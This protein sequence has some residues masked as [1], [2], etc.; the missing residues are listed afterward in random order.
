MKL[1]ML[2]LTFHSLIGIV[3]RKVKGVYRN[4]NNYGA[5]IFA[6]GKAISVGTFKTRKEAE[7]A[8]LSKR[9]ELGLRGFHD[10]EG[11]KIYICWGNMIQRCTNPNNMNYH[12]Y[13]KRGITVCRRW[14]DFVKFYEDMGGIPDGKSL[15]RIDN[16]GN[17][18]PLN[19]KWSTRSEQSINQR[20]RSDNKSGVKGVTWNSQRSKWVASIQIRGLVKKLY[21]GNDFF[22]AVCLRKS[23]ELTLT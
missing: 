13:G 9:A 22:E 11:T 14:L 3:M 4:G 20:I 23:I 2:K 15:D 16:N 10:M 18:E 7:D 5:R 12:R 8:I 21:Y 6:D 17:Y 19:C 1:R